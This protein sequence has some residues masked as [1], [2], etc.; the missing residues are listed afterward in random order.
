[1]T[2]QIIEPQP[3]DVADE[4]GRFG[5]IELPGDEAMTSGTGTGIDAA[6]SDESSDD[7][8]PTPGTGTSS[9][10]VGDLAG[11]DADAN[12]P[13]PSKPISMRSR[14]RADPMD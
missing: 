11:P 14:T 8:T 10:A 3:G 1:M 12:S 9:E 2:N 5:P 13:D 4:R 6:A 7:P